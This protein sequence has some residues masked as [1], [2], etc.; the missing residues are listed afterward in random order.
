MGLGYHPLKDV[1][2]YDPV[3]SRF[4]PPSQRGSKTCPHDWKLDPDRTSLPQVG[5][6][7][8]RKTEGHLIA[9]CHKCRAHLAVVL[10]YDYA[11]E[12]QVFEPC[13]KKDM[14]MH[15]F[16]HVPNSSIHLSPRRNVQHPNK[17]RDLQLF[18]CSSETCGAKIYVLFTPARLLQKWINQLTNRDAIADRHQRAIRESPTRFEGHGVPTGMD[19]LSNLREYLTNALATDE[20]RVIRRAN[21]RFTLSFGDAFGD[22]FKYLGFEHNVCRTQRVEE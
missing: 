19:V 17:D 5:S 1:P 9:H 6:V 16:V 3:H 8:A 14:P 21:K 7:D 12:N 2:Q 4:T 15:H 18:Q 11:S 20:Q 10:S 13:P 22:L